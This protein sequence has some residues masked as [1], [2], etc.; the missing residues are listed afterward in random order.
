MCQLVGV[1][2]VT[3]QSEVVKSD[4]DSFSAVTLKRVLTDDVRRI[5]VWVVG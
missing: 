4:L 5:A 3:P 1:G 2:D